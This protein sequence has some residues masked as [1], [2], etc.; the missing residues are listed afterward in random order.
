M[1]DRIRFFEEAGEEIEEQH[2]WRERL[3]H[4]SLR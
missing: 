1:T 3:S 2:Y 4:R